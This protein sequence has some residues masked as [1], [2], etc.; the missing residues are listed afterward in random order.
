MRENPLWYICGGQK[1]NGRFGYVEH[2]RFHIGLNH[3]PMT[4]NSRVRFL[5]K[6]RQQDRRD[7]Y[8][9]R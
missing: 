6:S 4:K 7:G 9:H 2:G 8:G 5:R 3:Q 1:N